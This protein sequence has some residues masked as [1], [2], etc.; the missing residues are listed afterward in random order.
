MADASSVSSQVLTTLG[1]GSGLDVFKLAQDLTDVEKIPKQ[2]AI[3]SVIAETE[4]SIS[5]YGLL[6]YQVGLLQSAFE[7][8]N[9]VSE[10]MESYG[11]SSDASAVS[12]VSLDSSAAAG[13]YDIA[14]TQLAQE[15]RLISD[16]YSSTDSTLNGSAFNISLTL[17]N[18]ATTSSTIAVTTPT[19]AGVVSAI[20]DAN[21]GVT[22]N[23]IDSGING[24][25]YRIVLSGP[26]GSE[27]AFSLSSTPDLGFSDN[28]HSI[29]S[30][31]DAIV[32]VEGL[33]ITRASNEF[34]D[35]IEGATIALNATTSSAARLTVTN[36]KSVLKTSLQDMV[37]TYND[38][39]T[40]ITELASPGSEAELGAAL[41]DDSSLIRYVKDRVRTAVFQDSSTPSGSID[42]LRDIGVSLDENG[43]LTF[44]EIA[45]DS[46]IVS[47]YDDVAMMLSANTDNQ[48]LYGNES[49]GLA[50]D[51]ATTLEGMTD[52]E[53]II[54]DRSDSAEDSLEGYR[55]ELT[56][57]E[58]RMEGVYQRYLNQFAAMESMMASLDTTKSYLEGQLESLSNMYKND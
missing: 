9:D 20:N 50:Q 21:T 32:T 28:E 44:D 24:S 51:I 11:T 41:A 53:G 14:V 40:I 26:T 57:L 1:V 39:N 33:P 54:T 34:S 49:K 22:A 35:V 31:Q 52:S 7:K 2:E 45:Y 30:A 5:G 55:E 42:G 16:E 17:G 25:N 13:A 36:D 3:Q 19:P 23:L 58:V 46:I 8:L 4:A 10:L 12:F 47:K 27:G 38:L 37:S 48:S 43:K 18:T 56:K 6:S 15:Q 29:Q